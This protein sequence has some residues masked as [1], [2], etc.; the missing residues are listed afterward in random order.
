MYL[1]GL[2]FLGL[3]PR[4]VSLIATSHFREGLA[5][6]EPMLISG[7]AGLK[8]QGWR[9]LDGKGC[10]NRDGEQLR[11]GSPIPPL[12]CDVAIWGIND[13]IRSASRSASLLRSF[14]SVQLKSA[15]SIVSN[16]PE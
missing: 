5:A 14:D 6:L 12:H 9:A 3:L 7:Q 8:V 2:L 16:R 13:Y 15:S 10:G 11:C 4:F 1:V